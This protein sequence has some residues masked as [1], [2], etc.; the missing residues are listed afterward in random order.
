V[1]TEANKRELRSVFAV[2]P[3]KIAVIPMAATT[4]CAARR[5]GA[6]PRGNSA[7]ATAGGDPLFGLIK[8]YKGLE[9]WSRR[10]SRFGRVQDA[11]S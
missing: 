10:S 4:S 8:R 9:F 7:A 11:F 3:A 6:K 1:H 2:E 5:P